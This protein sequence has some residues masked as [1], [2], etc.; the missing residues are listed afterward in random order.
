[1]RNIEANSEL[2]AYC[3]LYCGACKSYLDDKCNG[4]HENS[5][6]T[7]CQ[8]RVCCSEKHIQTCAECTEFSN[9]SDCK[10][11]NNFVS[12]LFALVF[13]S[14]RPACI[15]Q[16]KQLGVDGHARRMTELRTQSIK[17]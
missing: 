1:M 5:K 10:K 6:A 15:A 8:I 3:G 4:C 17:R 12:K 2:V 13:R 9:P 16:I 14:D 7:W 11:F